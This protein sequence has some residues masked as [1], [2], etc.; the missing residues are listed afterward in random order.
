MGPWVPW[1]PWVFDQDGTPEVRERNEH[2]SFRTFRIP[3]HSWD[4]QNGA[5][6]NT[7]ISHT[8]HVR[9]VGLLNGDPRPSIR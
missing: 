7:E 6:D 2:S 5:M 3:W 4:T 1:V 8:F 9:G